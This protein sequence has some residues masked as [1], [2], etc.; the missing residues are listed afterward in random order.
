MIKVDGPV[1][2]L[3]YRTR[4]TS[5]SFKLAVKCGRSLSFNFAAAAKIMT[6]YES[7]KIWPQGADVEDFGEKF[8]GF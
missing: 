8:N 4:S 6:N 1:N 7:V 5:A 2:F 3:R